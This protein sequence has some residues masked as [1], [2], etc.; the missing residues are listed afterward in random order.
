M[1]TGPLVLFALALAGALALAFLH[2]RRAGRVPQDAE[3]QREIDASRARIAALRDD[4]ATGRIDQPQ[5]DQQ[6]NALAQ[7]LLARSATLQAN[8]P[9]RAPDRR[10][11]LAIAALLGVAA[12][13]LI[14]LL[15]GP[16]EAPAPTAASTAS[17][18]ERAAA[19]APAP[20]SGPRAARALSDEQIQR[21][22]DETR[23]RVQANP[24]DVAAWAM[25]AHSYDM[26]GKFAE[27]S[28]AYASLAQLAP[29]DAQVLADYADALGVANGRTLAG[30]PAA[31]IRKALAIDPRN[32]KALTLAG[33]EAYERADYPGAAAQ[34]ERAR[35]LSHDPALIQQIDLSLASARASGKPVAASAPVAAATPAAGASAT[36]SGRVSLADDLVGKA[37]PDAVVFI[38]ARPVEGSRM[39]VAILRR[40]VRDLPLDFTLDDSM[41]MVRDVRLSQAGL[42]IIG[43]RVSKRGDVMPAA[44]DMQGMSAPIRVGAS[45]VKLEIS[46]VLK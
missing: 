31:L 18:A 3:L 6:E 26:L 44:G 13:A 43:A 21:M 7:E 28:K 42:V 19:S 40:H 2:P 9:P 10:R 15:A 20:A 30:E 38:F 32:V 34:W 35:A 22:I 23:A 1:Q 36:I 33:T 29:N 12:L 24:K 37:P 4:L 5:F 14:W 17:P 25:L 27:S 39:P 45:G 8:A 16:R 41:S 46:E 11:T